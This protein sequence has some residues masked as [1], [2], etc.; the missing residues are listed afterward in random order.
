MTWRGDISRVCLKHNKTHTRGHCVRCVLTTQNA[1]AVP[2][3]N[4][5][6]KKVAKIVND[7]KVE[8]LSILV[9]NIGKI[10]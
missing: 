2:G 4:D 10:S 9:Q 1:D 8:Y 5:I 3:L 6:F 7:V